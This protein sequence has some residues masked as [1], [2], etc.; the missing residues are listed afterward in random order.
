MES[1]LAVGEGCETTVPCM[2]GAKGSM[3]FRTGRMPV[4][5]SECI[6]LVPDWDDALTEHYAGLAMTAIDS[7]Q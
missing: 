2:I 6:M 7:V 5:G 1:G 4:I 3:K